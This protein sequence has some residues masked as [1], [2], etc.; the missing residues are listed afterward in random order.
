MAQVLTNNTGLVA[1]REASSGVLPGTPDWKILEPDAVSSFGAAITTTPRSPISKLRQ[2]RKGTITD[3]DADIEYDADQTFDSLHDFTE[4]FV[5]ATAVNADMTFRAADVLTTGYTVPAL[6]AAQA[7]KFQYTV[8]LG[9]FTLVHAAG[10]AATNNNTVGAIL[11]ITGAVSTSDV[12]I[13]VGSSGLTVET[14]PT[15]SEVSLAGIRAEAGDLALAVSG[16]IGTLTSNNGG[17]ATPLDFTTLGLTAGQTIHIGGLLTAN[18]MGSTAGGSNDS[19]GEARIREIDS[20]GQSLT[21][22]K[23]GTGLTASDGT[24]TGSAGSAVA[25]DL[26]FGRFIR[27]VSVDDADYNAITY[28]F[29]SA[30]PNLFETDPPTPVA[31][32]DGFE[33]VIGA[34]AN[35]MTWN[36]PLTD[37][38]SATFSFIGTNAEEPVDNSSR[39]AGAST[40]RS[41]LFT[42]AINTSSDFFR[43]GIA[44]VD[45][46]GLTSDFKDLTLTMNNNVSPEK[47]LGLLGARFMNSGNFEVD[48]EGSALFTNAEVPARVRE[49]TTVT[50]AWLLRNDEGAVAVD[51]PSATAGSDGKEYPVNETVRISMTLQAFTDPLFETS[52]GVSFFPVYPAA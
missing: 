37:K 6:T 18:R 30:Y 23:L 14:A 42:G 45:D 11:P 52:I 29:E 38:S 33:Y 50:A 5:A 28:T 24:D 2:R 16:N 35:Q 13:P 47:V 31:N 46:T 27:N 25:V 7:A 4:A 9:P 51:I 17:A 1:A 22:D 36:M 43:L 12:L 49:N 20:G 41:P 48:L 44:D 21:L 3:L 34:R 39:K 15:N 32:P 40:A 26:L 10:Y 19:F 8:T